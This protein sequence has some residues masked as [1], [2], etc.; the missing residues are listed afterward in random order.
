MER[1]RGP[2]PVRQTGPRRGWRLTPAGWRIVRQ[3]AFILG[4]VGVTAALVVAGLLVGA[5]TAIGQHLPSVDALYDLP[6]EATRIYAAD[7]ELIASLY[8]ENR[9]SVSLSQVSDT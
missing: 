2:H 6:N 4:L 1:F 7:G 3:A 9:D 5:A 8:R